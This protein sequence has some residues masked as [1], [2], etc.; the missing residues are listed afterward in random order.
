MLNQMESINSKIS[1][2]H[3][4]SL[5][6]SS[7]QEILSTQV[8]GNVETNELSEQ[9]RLLGTS[10]VLDSMGLV[11]LVV[12]VEQQLEEQFDVVLILADER[13]MSQTRSPFVS[14]GAF[15][16]YIYE[17]VQTNLYE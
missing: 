10:S 5:V 8:S 7:L 4:S 16:D 17:R 3:I 14:V 9:T 15:V 2:D 13:A 12:D 1:R 11:T 6:L